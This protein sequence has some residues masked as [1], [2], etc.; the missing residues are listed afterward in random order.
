M[1]ESSMALTSNAEVVVSKEVKWDNEDKRRAKSAIRNAMRMEMLHKDEP[2]TEEVL[3]TSKLRRMQEIHAQKV[4]VE[5]VLFGVYAFV[6]YAISY[7]G[8]DQRAFTLKNHLENT[9]ITKCN[10]SFDMVNTSSDYLDWLNR[11]FVPNFYPYDDCRGHHKEY[12]YTSDCANIR[13]GPPRLRQIRVRSEACATPIVPIVGSCYPSYDTKHED[14]ASY[15]PGWEESKTNC[16]INTGKYFSN[17]SVWSHIDAEQ[18]QAVGTNG[19][20]NAYSGGGYVLTFPSTHLYAE[21]M[22]SQMPHSKWLDRGT[23]AVF[24]EFTL[25]NP[26]V[27]LFTYVLILTE[28]PETG[29]VFR[30]VNIHAF[31]PYDFVGS[32]GTLSIFCY[33]VF[34]II[35][36]ISTFKTLRDL[37]NNRC[38]FFKQ[39]WNVIDLLCNLL[40]YATIALYVL[41]TISTKAVMDD[42]L[43]NLAKNKFTYF[44]RVVILNFTVEN[45]L[46]ILV[47]VATIRI[48]KILGYNKRLTE[49]ISVITNAIWDL[50]GFG[51][52]FAVVFMA[53]VLY[54]FLL[55]GRSLEG[56][57]SV[58]LAFGTLTNTLIGKNKLDTS[59]R[60]VP[61]IAQLY[62]FTYNFVVLWTVMTMFAAI[63]NKS[64]EEV[65]NQMKRQPTVYGVFDMFTDSVRSLFGGAFMRSKGK[66]Q[67]TKELPEFINNSSETRTVPLGSQISDICLATGKPTPT[68]TVYKK[69]SVG[70]FKNG[71]SSVGNITNFIDRFSPTDAGTYT[72]EAKNSLGT[73]YKDVTLSSRNSKDVVTCTFEGQDICNWYQSKS[74][75]TDWIRGTGSTST[76]GTGPS[77]DHTFQSTGR[78]RYMY[79]KASN[80][81]ANTAAR[82]ESLYIPTNTVQC[83]SLWYNMHGPDIGKLSILSKDC[84][85]NETELLSLSG[86]QGLN[87]Q[88]VKINI[89]ANSKGQQLVIEALRGKGIYGDIAIDDVNLSDTPCPQSDTVPRFLVQNETIQVTAGRAFTLNCAVTG[90]PAA[91]LV[92]EKDGSCQTQA[93]A[94]GS[95]NKDTYTVNSAK[96]VDGG[97]YKCTAKNRKGTAEKYITVNVNDPQSTCNFDDGSLS[98]CRWTQTTD[99]RFDFLFRSIQTPSSDTGP[100]A[101]HTHAN[102]NG[103]YIFLE[104][105][106]PAQVGDSAGIKSDLLPAGSP[107]CIDFWYN[108][109]GT[110]M[111]DLNVFV[112]G[113]S[114]STKK[115]KVWSISG[116]QGTDWHPTCF[117]VENRTEDFNIIIQ[118]TVGTGYHSDVAID[119][120]KLKIGDNCTCSIHS[121]S[122]FE[123]TQMKDWK[124][125]TSDDFDWTRGVGETQ[126][127]STGPSGDH[128]SG[129]GHYMYTEASSPRNPGDVAE[130]VSKTLPANQEYC[131]SMWYNMYGSSMG[132]LSVYTQ[133]GTKKSTVLT[134]SGDQGSS[135]H[136]Y[137][138]TIPLQTTPFTV[139]IA[140]TRGS[141]YYSD[142][143]IDDVRI[144]EGRC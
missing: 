120:V 75:G 11:V 37:K 34:I 29:S 45:F 95:N 118:A 26:N 109:Y 53:Y 124:Q 137:R 134:K 33:L 32:T 140:G 131:F 138:V 139:H 102:S 110:E 30:W 101:D 48:L 24:L 40:S 81:A 46:A 36:V 128:T 136:S 135:W 47:F 89:S 88:E 129:S 15:C 27:N 67:S 127:S 114:S 39:P 49:I 8:R 43:E 57:K 58:F 52:V 44:Q 104:S 72:C 10:P 19:E 65:R 42:F 63:L 91:S 5:L 99:D 126:S 9:F 111:G 141:G 7:I 100:N 144:D 64:I 55:F 20:Y 125:S 12:A 1:I 35:L 21:E 17:L 105:S 80:S 50:A 25:Y 71:T 68:L 142:M 97:V 108:M 66:P 69:D 41:R 86:D 76:L 22:V 106:N 90:K 133:H 121:Y 79:M 13:L 143:A 59:V 60:S 119:D 98:K 73:V 92:W 83:L 122:D 82:L 61:G 14:R 123:T 54:G 74:D 85:G 16:S 93:Q 3:R 70:C 78:G 132:R 117:K 103:Q 107:V 94:L 2:P 96:L 4:F 51:V 62:Y 31:R 112:L 18:L 87:W 28:F 23:R 116:N 84:S 130:L 38:T 6:I 115:D 113:C 56:Y 77:F